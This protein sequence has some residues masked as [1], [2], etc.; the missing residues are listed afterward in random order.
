[1]HPC[2]LT[3]EVVSDFHRA[4]DGLRSSEKVI[5][6]EQSDSASLS[7]ESSVSSPASEND[8][9]RCHEETKHSFHVTGNGEN[10]R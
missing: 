10:N 4:V 5:K 7:N 3:K 9:D 8:G 1:M 2:L 6:S